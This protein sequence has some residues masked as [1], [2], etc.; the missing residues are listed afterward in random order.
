MTIDGIKYNRQGTT[1]PTL[2][3]SIITE[4]PLQYIDA[5]DGDSTLL[6]A[7][8]KATRGWCLIILLLL[9]WGRS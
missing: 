1:R 4:D 6:Q 3:K 5:H 8:G 2:S 7:R 9:D